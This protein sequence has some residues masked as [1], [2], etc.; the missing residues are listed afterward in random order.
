M[1]LKKKKNYKTSV[2]QMFDL[3]IG[4]RKKLDFSTRLEKIFYWFWKSIRILLHF[5][6]KILYKIYWNFV[7]TAVKCKNSSL[8]LKFGI[9][10][11][12]IYQQKIQ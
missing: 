11:F 2:K 9:I 1:N 12:G 7:Q 5:S 4:G 6:D 8:V 3:E 10:E